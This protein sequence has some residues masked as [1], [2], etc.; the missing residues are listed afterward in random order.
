MTNFP[1][2]SEVDTKAVREHYE[3]RRTQRYI[4]AVEEGIKAQA[5]IWLLENNIAPAIEGLD[6]Y[7]VNPLSFT[8]G[9]EI[10]IPLAARSDIDKWLLILSNAGWVESQSDKEDKDRVT[11]HYGEKG[12]AL[13][14][15]LRPN[16]D[17]V[18]EVKERFDYTFTY[19]KSNWGKGNRKFEFSVYSLDLYLE[20]FPN[21]EADCQ[22]TDLGKVMVEREVQVWEVT[23]AEGAREMQVLLNGGD[24]AE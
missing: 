20:F 13:R 15:V 9:Y 4:A 23:C 17:L 5:S 12:N 8:T 10:Q 22:I 16:E 24:N 2:Q 11:R 19:V 7:S 18:N 14:Y 3:K 1:V 6:F 21:A